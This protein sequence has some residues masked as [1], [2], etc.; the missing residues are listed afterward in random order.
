MRLTTLLICFALF[1]G[2]PSAQGYEGDDVA[3]KSLE[4]L[5][6][7]WQPE[8]EHFKRRRAKYLIYE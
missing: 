2:P 8:L 6:Q 3:G 5:R 1:G 7:A 4:Q